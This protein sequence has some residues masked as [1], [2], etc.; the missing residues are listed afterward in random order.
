MPATLRSTSSP[1]ASRQ[2]ADRF[3]QT[4][5]ARHWG[6]GWLRRAPLASPDV[7]TLLSIDLHMSHQPADIQVGVRV[8]P[9]QLCALMGVDD[10][11]REALLRAIAGLDPVSRGTIV[12]GGEVLLDTATGV[13]RSAQERRM[14]LIDGQVRL[15]ERRTVARQLALAANLA[16]PHQRPS[17]REIATLADWF[18]LSACQ[19]SR[20]GTLAVARHQRLLLACALLARPRALLLQHL[21]D[22][23]PAADRAAFVDLLQQVRL[24]IRL[25]MLMLSRHPAE[26]IRLADEVIL[27]HE[28]RVAAAGPLA[29]VFSD[30]SLATF[31]EGE[32]AGSVLEGEV[33]RHDLDWLLSEVDVAGQWITVPAMLLE[34]GRRVRLKIRARDVHVH[35][36]ARHDGACQNQLRG[37]IAQVMLAGQNGSYGAVS[38]QLQGLRQQAGR[39]VDAGLQSHT[40]MI[41]SLM[42]RRSIEQLGL[43][44]G[45][46]CHVSFKAM[47]VTVMARQ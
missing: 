34:E 33:R 1:L 24:R 11:S 25:P 2:A 21:T 17:E 12:Q 42:T 23:L 26:A 19:G 10:G 7:S 28:G 35:R 39:T 29:Q 37:R 4:L 3:W 16:P 41:W 38:V 40:G 6:A 14:A 18:D 20:I 31:L 5:G 44:P 8:A 13:R 15:P 32:Q 22:P 9:G 47:A 30:V 27:L 43:E 36:E 45:Q 46:D